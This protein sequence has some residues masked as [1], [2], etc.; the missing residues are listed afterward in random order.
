M[1]EKSFSNGVN[2]YINGNK[3]YDNQRP[4]SPQVPP[5]ANAESSATIFEQLE[6]LGKLREA[7]VLTEEEFAEQKENCLINC[8]NKEDE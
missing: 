2:L 1:M 6:K 7:G 8:K 4:F 3:M 5:N